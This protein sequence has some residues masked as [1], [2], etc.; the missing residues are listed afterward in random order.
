MA[1]LRTCGGVAA[2]ALELLIHTAVRSGDIRGARAGEF[3]LAA[4]L[5]SVPAARLKTRRTRNGEQLNVPLSD[6]AAAIVAP[7]LEGKAPEALVFP[8]QTGKALSDM[9]L[10][11]VLRR[12]KVV[13]ATVHGF[14]SSF[15][16]WRADDGR[17]EPEV[18]EAAL[19]HKVPGVAGI[20]QR[21]ELLSRRAELMA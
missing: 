4:G 15:S 18:A 2:R 12:L 7:L 17:F 6:A 8:G 10:S 21:G 5:W 16:S 1:R 13:G 14:R 20:Y 3:D 11:A 9:S 19:G